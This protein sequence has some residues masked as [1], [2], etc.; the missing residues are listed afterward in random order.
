MRARQDVLGDRRFWASL[1]AGALGQLG[2]APNA[3]AVCSRLGV[4]EQAAVNWYNKF[5]GWH[6]GIF[7]ESD[8]YSD[9]PGSIRIA[10]ANGIELRAE[11]HPGDMYWSL[12]GADGAEAAVANVGPHWALP[13]LRWQEATAIS[14]A[15]PR[16]RW[17]VTLLLL[18][19]VWITAGDD[20]KAARRVAESAWSA[21]RLLPAASAAEG[22]ADLWVKAAEGGREYRWRRTR[23]GAYACDAQWSTRGSRRPANERASLNS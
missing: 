3:A 13:G 5:T 8:G 22:M 10:L 20:A 16:N 23:S 6:P 1:Y 14:A 12:R 7:D 2:A 9:D 11:F 21:S 17:A 18:P 4:R 15:A 19:V